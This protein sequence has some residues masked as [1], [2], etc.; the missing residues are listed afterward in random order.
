MDT[1][2]ELKALKS[3]AIGV[4]VMSSRA[5]SRIVRKDSAEK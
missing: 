2:P 5:V 3:K 4:L 1:I